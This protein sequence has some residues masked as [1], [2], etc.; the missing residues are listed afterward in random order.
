FFL[1]EEDADADADPATSEGIF[2]F[3]IGCPTAVAEGQRVRATGTVS[4]FFNMTEITASTAPSVVVTD[5]GNHLAEVTPAPID[6]P[7]VG[8]INTFYEKFEGMRVTFVDSLSVSEYFELFRY[9]QIELY[10]G[11]RPRQFTEMSPPSVAG[12]TA[13]LD[14]LDRRRV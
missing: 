3:C 4:E 2:V 12:N 9:G 6:L 1:Q 11:G 7:V 8:D 5:A 14:N 13:H 10:E